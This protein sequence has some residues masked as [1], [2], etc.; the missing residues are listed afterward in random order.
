[1]WVITFRENFFWEHSLLV[2]YVIKQKP[3]WKHDQIRQ[4]FQQTNIQRQEN[5][6]N[7]NSVQLESSG[8]VIWKRLYV[9]GTGAA[10]RLCLSLL[11]CRSHEC[12]SGGLQMYSSRTLQ[13]LYRLLQVRLCTLKT[14]IQLL[15]RMDVRASFIDCK[16]C[17]P[18]NQKF[19]N[20]N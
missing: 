3:D 19:C 1:M 17:L 20:I 7:W 18:A 14:F 9:W 8:S 12:C 11:I 4:S 16:N 2:G 15:F 13:G 5:M 10:Y 6:F